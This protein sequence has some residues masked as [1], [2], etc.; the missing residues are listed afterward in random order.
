MSPKG[1]IRRKVRTLLETKSE[2]EAYRIAAISF[3]TTPDYVAKVMIIAQRK[4]N[5]RSKLDDDALD[6]FS[7]IYKKRRLPDVVFTQQTW[8]SL[9]EN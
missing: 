7:D 8:F 5:K 2:S 9:L 3:N 4:P 6:N 1:N